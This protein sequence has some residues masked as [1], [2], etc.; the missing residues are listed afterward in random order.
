MLMM[1]IAVENGGQL[2]HTDFSILYHSLT[3]TASS[4]AINIARLD[5][6]ELIYIKQLDINLLIYRMTKPLS[7]FVATLHRNGIDDRRLQRCAETS[8]RDDLVIVN[9]ELPDEGQFGLDIYTR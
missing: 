9:L 7:D 3:T 2:K 1:I 5:S 4:I 8:V 6:S